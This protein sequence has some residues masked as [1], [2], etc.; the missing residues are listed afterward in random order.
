MKAAS[1]SSGGGRRKTSIVL[2]RAIFELLKD[3]ERTHGKA[4][5]S[6]LSRT[7]GQI[8]D[9][10]NKAYLIGATAG[11]QLLLAIGKVSQ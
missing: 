11:G 1:V 8:L 10:G 2:V 7:F 4:C 6:R 5:F 3:P 9:G